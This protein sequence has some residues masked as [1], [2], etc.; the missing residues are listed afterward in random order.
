M[1]YP[2]DEEGLIKLTFQKR[3][4][5]L[6]ILVRDFG[7]PQD[8]EMLERRFR[9][10]GVFDKTVVDQV[11]WRSFGPDGKE[12]QIVKWLDA[13]IVTRIYEKRKCPIQLPRSVSGD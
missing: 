4:S 11:H 2:Q 8:V 1:A 3:H 9:R 12:F 5:K 13:A 10:P 7:M 6:E